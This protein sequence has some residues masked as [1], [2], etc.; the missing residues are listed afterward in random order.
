MYYA[1][2]SHIYNVPRPTIHLW[3]HIQTSNNNTT[4]EL[5]MVGEPLV[6][7]PDQVMYQ[8]YGLVLQVPGCP[9]LGLLLL[10]GQGQLGLLEQ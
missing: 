4:Y 8:Q 2:S 3:L 10:Y 1:I 9:T 6:L 7:E 5:W